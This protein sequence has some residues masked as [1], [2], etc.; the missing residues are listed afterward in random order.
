MTA[1]TQTPPD[2]FRPDPP[3]RPGTFQ[4]PGAPPRNWAPAPL[5]GGEQ[6]SLG[7]EPLPQA[8]AGGSLGSPTHAR[9]TIDEFTPPRSRLP[10]VVLLIAV[11]AAA[12]IWAGTT[13][14][15]GIMS[16]GGSPSPSPSPSSAA[17]GLP[18]L[19]PDG[20]YSGRWQIL[21]H[22]WTDSGLEVEIQ[23]AADKG[24]IT[25]SFMAFENTSVEATRADPGSQ[26]PQFSGLPIKTGKQETGWLFFAMQRGPATI[27]LSTAG[28]NQMSALSVPG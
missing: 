8:E 11:L 12:L 22:Q 19:T 26:S 24:P 2:P 18:F 6:A 25:Y 1:M 16:A 3:G 9:V 4:T 13:L 10:L 20:R 28:G 23:I 21:E 15:P 27:I 5:S 14:R 7:G 17:A